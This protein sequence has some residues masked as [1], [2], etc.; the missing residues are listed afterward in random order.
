MSS[1]YSQMDAPRVPASWAARSTMACSTASRSSVELTAW[2]T[3]RERTELLDGAAELTGA[4]LQLAEQPRVLDGDDR[5]VGEGLQQLDPTR[6]EGADLAVGHADDAQD[7][8]SRRIGTIRRL[9]NA[10]GAETL[11]LSRDGLELVDVLNGE[12]SAVAHERERA[13]DGIAADISRV[14][15]L[16]ALELF[17]WD[18]VVTDEVGDLAVQ[19]V[20]GP[21][22]RAAQPHRVADD[23][24]EHRLGVGR[25]SSR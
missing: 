4:L 20:D 22:Q 15:A 16:H 13:M 21:V 9:R 19:A 25:S 10:A 23:G 8:R 18:V 7:L 17:R 5:L 11:A 14:V 12:D 24:V 6:R 2:P 1:S 3:S